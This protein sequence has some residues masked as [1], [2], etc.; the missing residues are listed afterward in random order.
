MG[1]QG[2]SDICHTVTAD[3]PLFLNRPLFRTKKLPREYQPWKTKQVL[4]PQNLLQK[5]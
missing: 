3:N 5:P 2:C 1:L 4:W